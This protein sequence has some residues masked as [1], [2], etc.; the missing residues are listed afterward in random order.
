MEFSPFLLVR[1]HFPSRKLND[2]PAEVRA[3]LDQAG[4][5]QRLKPGSTVAI[6][7]GSRG[8]ANIDVI[9]HS[10]VQWWQQQG[11][12]V[13]IFPAMGSHGA[14]SAKGQAAVLE[15]YGITA[16][17]MGCPI[18]SSLDVVELGRTPEGIHTFMDKNAHSADGVMLCGRVKW[19]TD[20]A[21]KIESGLF[22]MMAI[23]IGK[24]AGAQRYHAYAY[25]MGLEAMIR[26]VGRQVLAS[27]KILGGLAILED[28]NHDT[29][30]L[31]A[32]RVE[33]MEQ[34]EEEL[35]ALVK[36]WMPR[37]PFEAL[38]FLIINEIGKIFSGAGMD[39]KVVNRSVNGAYNP[40][41]NAPIIE[42]IF[43]RDLNPLSYGNAVG[44][45]MCDV[46]NTRVLKKMKKKPTYVNSIT[47]CTPAAI[48]VPVNFSTDQ[49]CMNQLW[50]TVGKEDPKELTMCW[51]RNSQ[52]LSLLAVTE[53]LR[54]AIESNP[55]LEIVR[56]AQPIQYDDNGNLV[57]WLSSGEA[58][59]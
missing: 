20:F 6:G 56:E 17:K 55:N 5:A 46:M 15:K 25:K 54:P 16:E 37:I 48:R 52:D 9:V 59:H 53:N 28:G 43:L 4:F 8:I 42:R 23:G 57:D 18:R 10:L 12:K 49:E 39:P 3:Q 27:G 26:S 2:I 1:Q 38:D 36:T 21:G 29:A 30:Q 13:F 32:V 22:K 19:H 35:Q 58:S 50:R 33:E 40:W 11:M 34:K 44:I 7:V 47:A 31:T 24:F 41:P 45:G 14:A 51:V